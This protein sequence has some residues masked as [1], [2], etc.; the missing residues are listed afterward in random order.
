MVLLRNESHT[1]S[2]K[3]SASGNK[4]ASCSTQRTAIAVRATYKI[5][6]NPGNNKLFYSHLC[7]YD[8]V[9]LSRIPS[10]TIN[11]GVQALVKSKGP[12]V[13][14][15]GDEELISQKKLFTFT[16]VAEKSPDNNRLQ[17]STYLCTNSSLFPP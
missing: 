9:S 14:Y 12:A 10:T 8:Q 15:S 16:V 11:F 13:I 2:G 6:C 7:R 3:R 17:T 5:Q 1:Y 4:V